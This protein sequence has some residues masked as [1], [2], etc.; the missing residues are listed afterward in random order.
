MGKARRSR[1]SA[2]VE[3]GPEA[4]RMTETGSQ[5]VRVSVTVNRHPRTIVV[6]C[7]NLL[8]LREASR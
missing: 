4:A 1:S 8:L 7:C 2:R 5:S 3:S 6:E